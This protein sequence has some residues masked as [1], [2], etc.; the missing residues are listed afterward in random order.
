MTAIRLLA[1]HSSLVESQATFGPAR[2]QYGVLVAGTAAAQVAL[3]LAD[4]AR[5]RHVGA[6]RTETPLNGLA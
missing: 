6:R 2:F 5:T 4:P 3:V 1:V